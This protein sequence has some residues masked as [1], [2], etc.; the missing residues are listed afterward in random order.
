MA[1]TRKTKAGELAHIDDSAERLARIHQ[2]AEAFS[3]PAVIEAL[4]DVTE[5]DNADVLDALTALY[6]EARNVNLD[7]IDAEV[8]EPAEGH[9]YLVVE[10]TLDVVSAF[11]GLHAAERGT[12]AAQVTGKLKQTLWEMG[13]MRGATHDEPEP[14]EVAVLTANRDT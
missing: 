1:S 2:V 3:N 7:G 14:V 10:A 11:A 9:G 5:L 13:R 8:P 6:A 4:A 12:M